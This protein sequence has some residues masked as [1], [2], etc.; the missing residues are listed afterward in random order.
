MMLTRFLIGAEFALYNIGESASV[1]RS[2]FMNTVDET[3]E[4]TGS[5]G[6]TITVIIND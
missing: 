5:G 4:P 2:R 6:C 3:R 1:K